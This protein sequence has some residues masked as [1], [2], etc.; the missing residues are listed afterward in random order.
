MV[1]EYNAHAACVIM[2]PDFPSSRWYGCS[3]LPRHSWSSWDNFH[4]VQ[5]VGRPDTWWTGRSITL[6]ASTEY[7]TILFGVERGGIGADVRSFC[8]FNYGEI[9]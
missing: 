2:Y 1:V 3:I 7:V 6:I 8:G 5:K 9:V 4:S